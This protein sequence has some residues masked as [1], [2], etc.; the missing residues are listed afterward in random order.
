MQGAHGN[1]GILQSITSPPVQKH[2]AAVNSAR[3]RKDSAHSSFNTA[4]FTKN[5]VALSGASPRGSDAAKFGSLEKK[6]RSQE[7]QL[8]VLS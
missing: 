6:V 7:K 1:S 8:H 4:D 2:A 3:C 5:S